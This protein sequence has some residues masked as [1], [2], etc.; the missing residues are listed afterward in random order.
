MGQTE[1]NGLFCEFVASPGKKKLV[2][3]L[4]QE[5]V[6]GAWKS[7]FYQVTCGHFS[8]NGL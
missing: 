3:V 1:I 2:A 7:M 5:H 4:S 6:L 8:V